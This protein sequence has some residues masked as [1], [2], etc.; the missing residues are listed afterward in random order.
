M[1]TG[2]KIS[3]ELSNLLV[4]IAAQIPTNKNL[5]S[6]RTLMNIPYGIQMS[7]ILDFFNYVF[8]KEL[9]KEDDLTPLVELLCQ[10]RFNA[11]ANKLKR[12]MEQKAL[13]NPPNIEDIKITCTIGALK[14]I[15]GMTPEMIDIIISKFG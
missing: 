7:S 4:N 10:I 9:V 3:S 6:L 8:E 5:T 1:A 11:E 13:Q 2:N 14:S 15:P 12:F